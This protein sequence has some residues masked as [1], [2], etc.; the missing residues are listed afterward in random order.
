[1]SAA[2]TEETQSAF[3]DGGGGLPGAPTP[4]SVLEVHCSSKSLLEGMANVKAGG[5]RSFSKRYQ[6]YR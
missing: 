1:M 6:A 5:G 4:L 3:G 2:E